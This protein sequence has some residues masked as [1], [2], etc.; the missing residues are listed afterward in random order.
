R[1][2]CRGGGGGGSR[3]RGRGRSGRG[4][5]GRHGRGGGGRRRLLVGESGGGRR[6]GRGLL[7][8]SEPVET[9]DLQRARSD[10]HIEVAIGI[11]VLALHPHP[12]LEARGIADRAPGPR[13]VVGGGQGAGGGRGV[14]R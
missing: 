6:G 3:A 4:R 9:A 11:D 10:R 7:R 12:G 14:S 5:R 1:R 8:G 13:L 2:C